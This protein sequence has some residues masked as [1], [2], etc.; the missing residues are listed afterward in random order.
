M[1]EDDQRG[2]GSV[3]SK[4]SNPMTLCLRNMLNDWKDIDADL[5]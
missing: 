2:I 1:H 5:S 4:I 3:A